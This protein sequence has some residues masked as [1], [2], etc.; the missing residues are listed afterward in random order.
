MYKNMYNYISNSTLSKKKINWWCPGRKINQTSLNKKI[1][2]PKGLFFRVINSKKSQ[3]G[4]II[5]S[6]VSTRKPFVRPVKS[7]RR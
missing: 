6:L 4:L 2:I 7:L 1:V 3:L 5:G